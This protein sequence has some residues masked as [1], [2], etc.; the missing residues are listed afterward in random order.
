[1]LAYVIYRNKQFHNKGSTA[2]G[3]SKT[4]RREGIKRKSTLLHQNDEGNRNLS[5]NR[6]QKSSPFK[7]GASYGHSYFLKQNILKNL[8]FKITFLFG[9][10]ISNAK[11]KL[12]Y[13]NS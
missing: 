10:R 6:F 8:I 1:M 11:F 4:Q 12:F 7:D 13:Q 3:R 2:I 5:E 9:I